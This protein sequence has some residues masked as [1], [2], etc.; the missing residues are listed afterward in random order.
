[1]SL[2]KFES[3]VKHL[4]ITADEA[5]ARFGNLKNLETLK[6]RLDDPAVR[7]TL[8]REAGADRVAEARAQIEKATFTEDM[9]CLDSPLGAVTLRIVERE[10]PKL[11]KF[12]GEGTPIPLYLW[13]Q[14]VPEGEGSKMR[15]TLGAEVNIFMKGMVKGPLTKAAEGLAS[16]LAMLAGK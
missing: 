2:S 11:L 6:S 10:S 13:L 15:V 3:E 7:E 14:F 12:A 5:Y 1:M 16:T 4:A 8:E 9:I